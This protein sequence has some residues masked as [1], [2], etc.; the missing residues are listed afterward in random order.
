MSAQVIRSVWYIFLLTGNIFYSTQFKLWIFSEEG[1]IVRD[2]EVFMS[3]KIA[4]INT[5]LL[6]RSHWQRKL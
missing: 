1:N 6:P 2:N 3:I 5:Q 4:K